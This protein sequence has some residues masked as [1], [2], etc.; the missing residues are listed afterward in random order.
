MEEQ[1][2]ARIVKF[3]KDNKISRSKLAKTL[4]MN[5]ATLISQL[6]GSRGLPLDVL[7][8]IFKTFPSLNKD[9]IFTGYGKVVLSPDDDTDNTSML[10][11]KIEGLENQVKDLEKSIIEKDAQIA[12][13]KEL[14]GK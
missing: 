14:L 11:A 4:G 10:I 2:T 3:L 1:V 8:Q 7:N 9:Y 5:K 6:N 13:L 12:L